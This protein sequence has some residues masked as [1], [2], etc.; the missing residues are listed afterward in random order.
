MSDDII[1]RQMAIIQAQ[2]VEI[3]IIKKDLDELI[4]FADTPQEAMEYINHNLR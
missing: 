4:H 1:Q 3:K 2:E